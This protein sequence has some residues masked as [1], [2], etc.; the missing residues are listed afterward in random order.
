MRVARLNAPGT[1]WEQ[2]WTGVSATSGGINQSTTQNGAEAVVAG[3]GGVPYVTW[4]ESDGTNPEIRVARLDGGTTWDQP[5]AG[6]GA[7]YGGVNTTTTQQ[8]TSPTLASINGVPFVAWEE[9]GPAPAPGNQEIRVARLS[10]ADLGAA[11]DGPVRYLRRDQRL[12]QR[13]RVRSEP[14]PDR[15]RALRGLGRERLDGARHRVGDPR[16]ATRRRRD[17]ARSRWAARARSTR[18]RAPPCKSRASARPAASRS[19]PGRRSLAQPTRRRAS[20]LEPEFSRLTATP[21]PLRP[22]STS[23]CS[24]SASPT[25]SASS[26]EWPSSAQRRRRS[27]RPVRDRVTISQR[28]GGLSQAR[29]YQF[30]PFAIA[31]VPAPRVFGPTG[32]FT[33][34]D[35][36]AAVMSR[37]RISP[38]AFRAAASEA[39][40]SRSDAGV[41]ERGSATGSPSGPR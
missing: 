16:G 40:A 10:G 36:T 23:T 29:R 35:A 5:W 33:T 15:R 20:R 27:H 2:P 12:R 6:A 13:E 18:L 21:P 8:G 31:G 25:P 30:R 38:T 39:E 24:P 3:V 4:F 37:F 26:S 34:R 41:R 32:T 17:L 19:S 11:V 28:A 14:E 1:G 9:R 7:T 22:R